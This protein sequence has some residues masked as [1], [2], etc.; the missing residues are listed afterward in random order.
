MIKMQNIIII[1]FIIK[2]KL[3]IK[4]QNIII[5]HFIIKVQLIIKIHAANN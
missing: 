3:I 5:I 1:H 2:V 4:M